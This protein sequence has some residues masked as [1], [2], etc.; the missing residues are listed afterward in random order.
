MNYLCNK[1]RHRLTNWP[2]REVGILNLTSLAPMIAV[3][4]SLAMPASAST[5]RDFAGYLRGRQM[6]RLAEAYCRRELASSELSDRERVEL[7]IELSLVAVA[8]AY[9]TP[10][11]EREAFWEAAR[12]ALE[13]WLTT[14]SRP[15]RLLAELQ[16]SLNVLTRVELEQIENAA[17]SDAASLEQRQS[18]VRQAIAGLREVAKQ[19]EIARRQL[20]MGQ[21]RGDFRFTERELA[22]LERS[23][24]LELARGYRQQALSYPA[25]SADRVNADQQSVESLTRLAAAEPADTLTWRARVALGVALAELGL[26]ERGLALVAQWR[27]SPPPDGEL[28]NQLLAAKARLLASAGRS[29][30]ALAKLASVTGSP[31]IDMARLELLLASEARDTQAIDALLAAIRA[32]HTAR[33]IRQ[34]EAMVGQ[35]FASSGASTAVGQVHAAEHFYR[36]GQLAAAVAAYD[37]A[38]ELYRNTENRAEAFAAER[39]AAAIM[40]Q[41]G[42]HTEAAARYRR[43]ALGSVDR[44]DSANDHREAILC[45]AALARDADSQAVSQAMADYLSLC[46]EH[47]RHW[48]D[49]QTSREVEWWLARALVS[50]KQ[51]QAT[52]DVLESVGPTSPYYEPAA[53]LA[54]TAYRHRLANVSDPAERARLTRAAVARLQPAIVGSGDA[55]G[56]PVEWTDAQR[57]CA[58]EL[59]RLMLDVGDAAYAEKLLTKAL[60]DAPQPTAEFVD[61][62]SPVLAVALVSGGKTAEA[63]DLL[64]NSARGDGGS[65]SLESLA[66]RLT[67]DLAKLARSNSST[68]TERAAIGQLLLA[69]LEVAGDGAAAWQPSAARY[70]AAALAAV[71][72]QA[73]ARQLYDSLSQQFPKSGDI[74]EEYAE[75]LATGETSADRQAALALYARIESASRRGAERWRRARQARI[76][77]LIELGRTDE[78]RKL[79]KL[80]RLLGDR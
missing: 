32:S 37:Q 71:G 3:L 67:S 15:Y 24:A 61:R 51:W 45:L 6:Y 63:I 31:A 53:A 18:Q 46:R 79:E 27:E 50:R 65:A 33:Y 49:G 44:D 30:V 77:L 40:Q 59:A 74:Q 5:H 70:R 62:A 66:R 48:P 14:Q 22:G 16:E 12:A 80:T 1:T 8:R 35:Q 58:L 19:V 43:L 7:A 78:A 54:A 26:S 28:F 60:E 69:V 23:V 10:P 36:A 75:L 47:L 76:D 57:T 41:Q 42:N 20:A 13:P 4:A 25:G 64:K 21:T 55:V 56:W 29:D 68:T 2:L 34:A 52:L 11:S 73:E 9:D 38:A 72:N 17:R 39:G